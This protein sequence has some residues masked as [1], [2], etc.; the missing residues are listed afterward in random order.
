VRPSSTIGDAARAG[1]IID[2]TQ[3]GYGQAFVFEA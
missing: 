1:R 3:D 2:A